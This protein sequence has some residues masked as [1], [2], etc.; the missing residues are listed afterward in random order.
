MKKSARIILGCANFGGVGSIP[1]LVGKGE[2]EREAHTLLDT[3]IALGIER[4]DTANGYGKGA[5][6]T[7]LGNWLAKRPSAERH[8]LHVATKVGNPLAT[9]E[10]YRPLS[11]EEVTH[12]LETSLRR[13]HLETIPL[14]YLHVMDPTT[15][16]E[17]TLEALER[18]IRE[19]KIQKFGLSNVTRADVENVIAKAG[20]TLA[21]KLSHV[22]NEFHV[23]KTDDRND[24]LPYLQSQAIA[25]SAYGPLAGG[26]LTGKYISTSAPDEGSRLALRGDSYTPYLNDEGAAKIQQWVAAAAARNVSPSEAAIDFILDTEGIESVIIGPRRVE[27]FATLGIR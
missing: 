23:L 14:Y 27:H 4:F 24:L 10:G 25:Y 9:R 17:E 3:A 7:F 13:L 21:N 2:T 12:H 16:I 18:A 26:L 20:P 8:R 5:S 11:R 6:E 15:P 1:H 19:G 22:E